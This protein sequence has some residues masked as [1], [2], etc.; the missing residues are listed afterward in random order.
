MK[1]KMRMMK[2]KVK[3]KRMKLIWKL[4][5]NK[6]KILMLLRKKLGKD[7]TILLLQNKIMQLEIL[8]MSI[9]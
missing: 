8:S 1:K 7:T 2:M 3:T 9:K 6:V 5:R 4:L